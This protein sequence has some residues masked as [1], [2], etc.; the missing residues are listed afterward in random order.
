MSQRRSIFWDYF[1]EWVPGWARWGVITAACSFLASGLADGNFTPERFDQSLLLGFGVSGALALLTLRRLFVDPFRGVSPHQIQPLAGAPS[2]ERVLEQL[3][4]GHDVLTFTEHRIVVSRSE[5]DASGFGPGWGTQEQS[6]A[7][8]YV[9][10]WSY[11]TST[12][13]RAHPRV[14]IRV[15]TQ[16]EPIIDIPVDADSAAR[17]DEVLAR[18]ASRAT[19]TVSPTPRTRRWALVGWGLSVIAALIT[20]LTFLFGL[21][22]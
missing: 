6:W 10:R 17:V 4:R 2:D 7:Y 5:P 19:Q 8:G 15:A 13:W 11:H 16:S 14:I 21:W 18:Q 9:S 20:I 3:R 12:A 1:P 22:P